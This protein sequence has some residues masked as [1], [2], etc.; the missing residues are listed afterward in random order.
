MVGRFDVFDLL[1]GHV[2]RIIECIV[3]CTGLDKGAFDHPF[4]DGL[5]AEDHIGN[6]LAD[7]EPHLVEQSHPFAFELNLRIHLPHAAE[8]DA[9]SDMVHRQQVILPARVQGLQ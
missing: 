3:P 8:P 9:R 5:H 4:L 6:L 7:R 1:L 2:L